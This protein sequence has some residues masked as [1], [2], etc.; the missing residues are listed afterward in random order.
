METGLN[1]AGLLRARA[2]DIAGVGFAY[3]HLSPR[4]QE[5]AASSVST[6]HEAILEASYLA[7]ISSWCSLQPDVQ[8]ILNPGGVTRQREA[9]VL[10]LR[11]NLSF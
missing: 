6:H 2:N 10:G 7:V 9:L 4:E 8:Y 11:L 1:Y 3:T 5:V